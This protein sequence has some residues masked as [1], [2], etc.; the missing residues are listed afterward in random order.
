MTDVTG[1]EL[2]RAQKDYVSAQEINL[3]N[4]PKGVYFIRLNVD[5]QQVVKRMVVQ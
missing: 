1:K 5:E 2:W 3:R 4:F